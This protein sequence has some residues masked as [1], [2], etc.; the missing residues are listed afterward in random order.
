M[1][2]DAI[3]TYFLSPTGDPVHLPDVPTTP[4]RRLRD[5]LEAIATVGWWS[6]EAA[7]GLTALGH[8]FFDGYVWGR[9]AALG[10]EP[11]TPWPAWDDFLPDGPDWHFDRPPGEGGSPQ[12]LAEVLYNNPLS[13]V[14]SVVGES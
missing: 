11:L 14:N 12:L 9:A 8:G 13:R 4:A 7:A 3:A 10:A 1:D 6:R 5:S 2:Y